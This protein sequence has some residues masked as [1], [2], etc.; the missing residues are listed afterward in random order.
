MDSIQSLLTFS[1]EEINRANSREVQT[2]LAESAGILSTI[3][4]V[5][6]IYYVLYYDTQMRCVFL[7][8]RD[9]RIYRFDINSNCYIHIMHET[10]DYTANVSG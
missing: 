8:E 4:V 10:R 5:H 6:W 1:R 2:R 7:I 9:N 3:Q